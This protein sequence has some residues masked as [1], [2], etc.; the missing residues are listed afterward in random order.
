MRSNGLGWGLLAPTLI[1]LGIMGLLPFFYV[2]YVGFF[3]WNVFS[4]TG[5]LIWAGAN[6]YRRLVFDNDFLTSLG[7]TL[8]FTGW[9]VGIE[10]VLGFL[11]ANTLVRDFPGKT[12]F[13]TIHALPLMVAPI[14]V[15]A[16]WRLLTIP[17]FGLVPY[18][19]DHWFGIDYNIGRHA[20]HAF[21]TTVVMDPTRGAQMAAWIS[22]EIGAEVVEHGQGNAL[23][24]LD[25]ERFMEGLRHGWLRHVRDPGLTQHALNAVARLLPGGLTRF[26]RPSSSRRGRQ[27]MRR[28]DALAAAVMVYSVAVAELSAAPAPEGKEPLVAWV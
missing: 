26:D 1:I 16:T 19:L 22:E 9:A 3:D 12:F 25:Y 17:G 18:Y 24:V 21:I 20:D 2:V 27:R 4:A 15:G 5:T 14:A 8:L 7:R 6:N 23:A 10:L 28:I 13:R 11:L